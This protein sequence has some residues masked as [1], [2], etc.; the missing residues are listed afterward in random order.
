MIGLLLDAAVVA[1]LLYVFARHNANGG[2]LYGF[3]TIFAVTLVTF[4]AALALP[5]DLM[6]LIVPIYLILMAVGLTVICGTQ[7][8]QTAKILGCFLGYR[9]VMGLLF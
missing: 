4:G 1:G 9:I 5:P 7:P 8:K 2:F 6:I 3:L